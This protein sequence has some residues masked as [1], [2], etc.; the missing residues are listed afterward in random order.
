M[1]GS[2][3][4]TYILFTSFFRSGNSEWMFSATRAWICFRVEIIFIQSSAFCD[5]L[6]FSFF[7]SLILSVR[8]LRG[9]TLS[10]VFIFTLK[11]LGNFDS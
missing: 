7:F 3:R 9:F 5:P 2:L 11:R 10:V 1:Y 6:L 8:I 4:K